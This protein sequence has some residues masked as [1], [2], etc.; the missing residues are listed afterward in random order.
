MKP[1]TH[2]T[3]PL[4]PIDTLPMY[5]EEDRTDTRNRR[6]A[7]AVAVAL[8]IAL[9][10]MQIP[11]NSAEAVEPEK[12]DVVTVLQQVQFK[13][14]PPPTPETHQKPRTVRMPMPDPTPDDPEPIR[15]E[16][17]IPQD[18]N[19]NTD[20]IFVLPSEPPPITPDFVRAGG[21]ILP[22]VRTHYVAPQYTE[23]ARRARVQGTVV[24]DA[25]IDKAGNVIDAQILKA[26]P[27][28]LDQSALEA[29]RQWKFESS[30]LNGKPVSVYYTVT[31]TFTLN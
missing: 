9:L 1:Q 10:A 12:R 28:G 25:T 2:Q 30:T 11:S 14:P 17:E 4:P 19:V 18:L 6:V 24:I 27:M 15:L 23:I 16:E 13:P 5:A 20:P 21:E 3:E 29:V 8:H 31:V 22:P 26:L 7:L